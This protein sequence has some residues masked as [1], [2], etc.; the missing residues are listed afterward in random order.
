[1]YSYVAYDSLTNQI[2]FDGVATSSGIHTLLLNV[3]SE[4]GVALNRYIHELVL[5][6]ATQI[7]GDENHPRIVITKVGRTPA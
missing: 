5:S 3:S 4:S 7:N 6:G 2:I 1:M